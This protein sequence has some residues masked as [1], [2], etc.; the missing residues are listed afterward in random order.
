MSCDG[1]VSLWSTGGDFGSTL[2][3]LGKAQATAC[4]GLG[5]PCVARGWMHM[6][7]SAMAKGTV[8]Y[9]LATVG[10]GEEEKGDTS[11]GGEE[12][13]SGEGDEGEGCDDKGWR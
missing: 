9:D 5:Q 8:T 13:E 4:Y 1:G 3:V 11:T 10:E 7:R 12:A 6:A 2:S